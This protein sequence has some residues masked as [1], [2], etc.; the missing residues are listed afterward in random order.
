MSARR[1]EDAEKIIHHELSP[2]KFLLFRRAVAER[3]ENI[4]IWFNLLDFLAQLAVISNAFLIAFTSEFIPKLVYK[5]EHD[6]SLRGYVNYTLAY[7]PTFYTEVEHHAPCRYRAYRDHNGHF[8]IE[9]WKIFT[10][11]LAFVI[12]FEVK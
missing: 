8:T 2:T 5:Y 4:G 3:A 12:I 1:G 6:W 10:I 11:K 7:S 9:H